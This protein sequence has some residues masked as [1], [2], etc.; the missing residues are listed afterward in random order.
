MSGRSLIERRLIALGLLVAVLVGV[1]F[2]LVAPVMRGFAERGAERERLADDLSR[3]RRLIAEAGYWRDQALRL[4]RDDD[5]FQLSAPNAE[6]VARLS[7]EPI[8][9]A[10]QTPGGV[11]KS[12][13]E[14]PPAPGQARLRVEAQLTLT[15]LIASLKLLEGQKPFLVIEGLA[16]AADPAT[17]AG[18][19]SPLEVRIDLAV[20]YLVKSG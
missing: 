7:M 17:A 5:R 18:Q 1:C 2:G 12:L 14:Q 8:S 9:A 3:G 11:L 16:I 15:Q 13:R 10:I 4:R 20:P 6:G 19:L